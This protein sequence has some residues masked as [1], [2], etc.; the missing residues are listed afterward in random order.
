MSQRSFVLRCTALLSVG[1]L[2][3]HDLRYRLAF[4]EHADHA[5]Q[6]HGHSY[7]SVVGPLV[8][9]LVAVAAGH[10]LWLCAAG[11]ERTRSSS[12][13]RLWLVASFAL[14]TCFGVQ[15][16]LEG[17]LAPGHP[18]GLGGTFGDGGWIAVPL[19]A[20]AG[21][22]VAFLARGA[23]VA[24]EAAAGTGVAPHLRIWS[25]PVQFVA[26]PRPVAHLLAPLARPG[27]GRAPPVCV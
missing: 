21:L 26:A 17:A 11:G 23:E 2:V 20:V 13:R 15:E 8:G 10:L 1:I 16:L 12:L 18:S 25:E 24:L 22:G 14:L 5:L 27:A 6:A 4:G 19:S 7:L 3:V 9:L